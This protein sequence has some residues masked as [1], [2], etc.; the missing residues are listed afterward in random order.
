MAVDPDDVIEELG[1]TDLSDT[2]VQTRIDR[3]GR[4][5]DNLAS[6]VDPAVRDDVVTLLTAHDIVLGPDPTFKSASEGSGSVDL[7]GEFGEGIRSTT[8]G[9]R[10]QQ[11][12]PAGVLGESSD[13][14]TL[15][16]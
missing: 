3:V 14:F 5:Y 1:G 10:A 8:F 6:G 13:D 11:Y 12:D 15:S 16:P 4:F 7:V 2:E 9:Q